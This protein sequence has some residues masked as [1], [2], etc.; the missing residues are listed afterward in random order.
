MTLR[1]WGTDWGQIFFPPC[2]FHQGRSSFPMSPTQ[3]LRGSPPSSESLGWAS[4]VLPPHV[5]GNPE[6]GQM[7]LFCQSSRSCFVERTADRFTPGD[8]WNSREGGVETRLNEMLTCLLQWEVKPWKLCQIL[9]FYL[10]LHLI[11][12]PLRVY[13][14]PN[15]PHIA[16]RDT[17]LLTEKFCD[18]EGSVNGTDAKKSKATT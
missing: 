5:R 2:C 3:S 8:G 13:P 10:T 18:D 6:R 12:L 16:L 7:T 14:L 9:N 17:N 4:Q 15:V 11:T 1:D